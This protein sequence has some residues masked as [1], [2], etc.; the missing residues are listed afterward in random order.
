MDRELLVKWWGESWNEGLWAAAWGKA[1][2]GL[3]AKQAATQPAP[4][5]KS[6]WQ[7]VNHMIFWRE[8]HLAQ[9]AGKPKATEA[10][11]AKR[12]WEEPAEVTDAAW[13]ATRERFEKTQKEL[14]A[15]MRD[16]KTSIE[17]I[18]Y[19][20]PHDCYHMGQIN[21]VRAWLGLKAIE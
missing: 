20:L 6:I 5:R 9:L 19:F 14:G 1:I 8:N 16:P 7:I 11:V 2:D 4:G 10:E 21:Y 17:R 13:K 18:A 15:A 3:T 12:N